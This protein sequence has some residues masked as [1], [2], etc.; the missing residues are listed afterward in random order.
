MW[1]SG[2]QSYCFIFPFLPKSPDTRRQTEKIRFFERKV[3]GSSLKFIKE[4]N[5]L[6]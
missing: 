3:T 6:D 2:G 4:E 1:A 5:T